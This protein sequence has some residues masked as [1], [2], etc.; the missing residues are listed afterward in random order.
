[1]EH[2]VFSV[3][4]DTEEDE[5]SCEVVP[6]DRGGLDPLPPNQVQKCRGM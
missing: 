1:M 6:R 3:S 2:T 4:G 5:D